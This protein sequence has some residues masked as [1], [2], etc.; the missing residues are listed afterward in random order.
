MHL[1]AEFMLQS[2][3]EVARLNAKRMTEDQFVY[4]SNEAFAGGCP[5]AF[6]PDDVFN[7]TEIMFWDFEKGAE[8][9]E[10]SELRNEYHEEVYQVTQVLL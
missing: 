10:W 8:L 4:L 7:M 9:Q 1:A 5:Q 3:L 2:V 6:K